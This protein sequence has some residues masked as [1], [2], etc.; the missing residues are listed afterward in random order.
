VSDYL[1]E[2]HEVPSGR[3]GEGVTRLIYE[4]L[5]GLQST[6]LS[7]NEKL[8]KARRVIDNLQAN[9]ACYNEHCENL[10]HQANQNGF[11]QMFN[12]GD[13]DLRA[14]ASHN[15]HE[16]AGKYQEVGTAMMSYSN[17]LQ[18]FDPEGS[19]RDDLGLGCWMYMRFVGDDR[20]VTGVICGYSPHG[21][22]AASPSSKK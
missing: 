3:K 6:L 7:K 11:C 17:L 2:V 20:I 15:V 21:V 22:P 1:L 19:G 8:E 10:W 16:T 5:N 4:N 12:G 9:V 13:T 14:I 18:Q